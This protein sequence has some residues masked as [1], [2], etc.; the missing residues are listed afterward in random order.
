MTHKLIYNS[1]QM[2]VQILSAATIRNQYDKI[3]D[4]E[5]SPD[6]YLLEGED[7]DWDDDELPFDDDEDLPFDDD[8][9]DL[10]LDEDFDDNFDDDE[11][12][13]DFDEDLD[14]EDLDDLLN[15]DFDEDDD[16]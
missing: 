1:N 5:N 13:D 8:E 9:D 15:E 6:D 2:N 7:D 12:D 3:V 16:L 11:D 4:F 10:S 14:E